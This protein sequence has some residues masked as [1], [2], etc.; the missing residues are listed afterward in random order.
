MGRDIWVTGP[1]TPTD[2]LPASDHGH[3]MPCSAVP[4]GRLPGAFLREAHQEQALCGAA[5]QS[6]GALA[7][8]MQDPKGTLHGAPPRPPPRRGH[9][10]CP[11]CCLVETPHCPTV[12]TPTVLAATAPQTQARRHIMRVRT[13][14]GSAR[15][16]LVADAEPLPAHPGPSPLCPP[17]P[18]RPHQ[19]PRSS[20]RPRCV[21]C[22]CSHSR[23][24]AV[25][26]SMCREPAPWIQRHLWSPLSPTVPLCPP[27][28]FLPSPPSVSPRPSPAAGCPSSPPAWSPGG[29]GPAS[30]TRRGPLGAPAA[31]D[32][33][34]LALPRAGGQRL[35]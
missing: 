23:A 14:Q 20:P 12:S 28:G 29:R 22:P 25:H 19:L 35:N 16:P 34:S 31:S 3:T 21:T 13:L 33:V 10:G 26:P 27:P 1:C 30:G 7:L 24:P 2:A 4:Y 32:L 11:H 9:L 6:H 15:P 8:P 5:T 18:A 17:G